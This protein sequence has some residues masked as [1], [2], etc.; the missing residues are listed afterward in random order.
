MKKLITVVVITIKMIIKE[1]KKEYISTGP[2]EYV[3]EKEEYNKLQER[4]EPSLDLLISPEPNEY[5]NDIK[6]GLEKVNKP[7]I[8]WLEKVKSYFDAKD[9][10]REASTEDV[11]AFDKRKE[12]Y[13]GHAANENWKGPHVNFNDPSNVRKVAEKDLQELKIS[14]EKSENIVKGL[15]KENFTAPDAKANF[16]KR[17][18]EILA[19]H[20]SKHDEF[21]K[22]KDIR[23]KAFI[24]SWSKE[25]LDYMIRGMR[26][27][28]E[29]LEQDIKKRLK[30]NINT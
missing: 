5:L 7:G 2:N 27:S 21:Y 11:N 13:L 17:L 14:K 10:G 20:H 12:R 23:D 1:K 15:E 18:D 4:F 26:E 29:K 16:Y 28:R 24:D 25:T 3:K 19:E 6:I 22:K 8:S 9:A 30:D